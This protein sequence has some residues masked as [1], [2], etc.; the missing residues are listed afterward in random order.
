MPDDTVI[1]NNN[2]IKHIMNKTKNVVLPD[3]WINKGNG[4]KDMFLFNI[5][6]SWFRRLYLA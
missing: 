6:L 3:T 1:V 2:P 5:L 4:P